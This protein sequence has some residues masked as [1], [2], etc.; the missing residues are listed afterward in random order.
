M[1]SG[2]ALRR[3]IALSLSAVSIGDPIDMMNPPTCCETISS[4]M[5]AHPALETGAKS[6]K[7]CGQTSCAALSRGDIVAR[8]ESDH[9][10]A[11]GD[12]G[13]GSGELAE[14]V[15]HASSTIEIAA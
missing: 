10:A 14:R 12:L 4:L 2:S 5:R 3:C 9:A 15:E 13:A 1:T 8:T 7:S 6:P 11:A